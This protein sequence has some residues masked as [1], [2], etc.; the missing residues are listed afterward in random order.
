L[1]ISPEREEKRKE[2]RRKRR[3][4]NKGEER[5]EGRG[6]EGKKRGEEGRGG[7]E[8]CGWPPA[9]TTYPQIVRDP[10]GGIV[11]EFQQKRQESQTQA[12][13][14]VLFNFHSCSPHPHQGRMT[15]MHF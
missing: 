4:E 8:A 7:K 13:L 12:T 11:L 9:W 5:S 3:G 14:L 6:G 10:R 2:K 15:V 1:Y